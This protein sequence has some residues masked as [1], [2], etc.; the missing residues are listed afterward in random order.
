MT[1]F[2]SDIR[3]SGIIWTIAAIGLTLLA[4]VVLIK[5]FIY[6]KDDPRSNKR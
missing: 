1:L 3:M 4:T 5:L 2:I 6:D